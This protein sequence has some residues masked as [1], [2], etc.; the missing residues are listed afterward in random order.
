MAED[1]QKSAQEDR[2]KN[3]DTGPNETTN[4]QP[5]I[6]ECEAE[7]EALVGD[8]DGEAGEAGEAEVKHTSFDDVLKALGQFGRYQK[9]V[10]FLLFM[11][12]IFCAMHK[13]AW[14][15]LGAQVDHRC[16]LP[17]M[18]SSIQLLSC[19]KQVFFY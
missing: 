14:V 5:E 11:P 4:D 8:K 18:K 13:L 7:K 10:Y 19:A 6:K 1:N 2:A 12:T 15:F 3:E 16:R 9:R 17:G